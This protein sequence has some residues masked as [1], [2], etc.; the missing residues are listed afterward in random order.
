M[1][2]TESHF[3]LETKENDSGMLELNSGYGW[4]PLPLSKEDFEELLT[5]LTHHFERELTEQEIS[6]LKEICL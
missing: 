4:V 5:A 1:R 2:H 6:D 3:D